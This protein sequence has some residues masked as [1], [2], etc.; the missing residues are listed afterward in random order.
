MIKKLK[1][2]ISG[3]DRLNHSISSLSEKEFNGRP[4]VEGA[5][6]IKEH[7]IHLV[8][9]EIN[10]FI[11]LKSIFAQP[12]SDCYVMDEEPWTKNLRRKNEDLQKYIKIFG[13]IRDM[14]FDLM[15][16]ESPE[17]FSKDG[18]FR[19]YKNKREK[20]TLEKH[21]EVYNNHLKFHIDYIDKI[22]HGFSS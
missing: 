4:D 1:E 7:I 15:K 2:Y 13:L 18:Y 20:I 3:A 12:G 14:A 5:W 19:T 17:N 6:T 16:D 9:S 22:K 10:G 8:D 21:L 11:R